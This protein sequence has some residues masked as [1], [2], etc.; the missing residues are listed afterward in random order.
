MLSEFGHKF[1]TIFRTEKAHSRASSLPPKFTHPACHLSD[2]R[3]DLEI[4]EVLI[5][6]IADYTNCGMIVMICNYTRSNLKCFNK[7]LMITEWALNAYCTL[8]YIVKCKI[9]EKPLKMHWSWFV[10]K[11]VLL[12]YFPGWLWMTAPDNRKQ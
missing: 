9:Q 10:A 3:F 6:Q 2:I 12:N 11:Y 8:L 7:L 4:V 5:V 1:L